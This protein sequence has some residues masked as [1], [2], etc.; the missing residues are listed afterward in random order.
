M[1]SARQRRMTFCRAA[2]F[3]V[4]AALFATALPAVE[5]GP[6]ARAGGGVVLSFDDGCVSSLYAAREMEERGLRGTFFVIGEPWRAPQ[7][8]CPYMSA[9][10]VAG[11]ASRGHD[12]QAHTMSHRALTSLPL[13]EAKAELA[14][15]RIV[16]T[17]QAGLRATHV[18]YPYGDTNAAVTA[19]AAKLF[20]TARLYY[21]DFEQMP[22]DYPDPHLLSAIGVLEK[23][24]ASE[25]ARWLDVARAEGVVLVLAIHDI[26]DEPETFE[27][28]PARYEA[29]LDTV[30]R[31]GLP[32]MTMAQAFG[33]P[34][35][36]RFAPQNGNEWWVQVHL[37]GADA[38]KVARLEARDDNTPWTPLAK[39]SWGGFAASFR[40]EP[41]HRVE[42]RAVLA[43]GRIVTSCAFSHPSGGCAGILGATGAASPPGGSFAASFKNVRGNEWWVETDVATTGGTLTGVDARVNGGA[44][45][46]LEKR[47][48]GSWAKSLKAPAGSSVEFRARAADGQSAQSARYAW[49]PS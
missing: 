15:S 5:A 39:K 33:S 14:G 6:L 44:W 34:R 10:Q 48:W 23:T 2:G 47:S 4:A 21:T 36:V 37:G 40:V 43:D 38:A 41:G 20:R 9:A 30:V 26:N 16:S 42:Y 24:T 12:I 25:V 46:A 35:A 29:I 19:E 17:D 13:S 49:P 45:T 22:L 28:T 1:G 31:S 27:T 18:A 8:D 32:V 7:D 11:L 3:L